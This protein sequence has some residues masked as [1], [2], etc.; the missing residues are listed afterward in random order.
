LLAKQ[1]ADYTNDTFW[2]IMEK[3]AVAVFSIVMLMQ[4]VITINKN[5]KPNA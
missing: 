2:N 5:Q 4:A 3:P 1:V